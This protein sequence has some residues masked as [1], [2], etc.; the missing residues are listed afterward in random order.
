M[1][2]VWTS[3]AR[4]DFRKVNLDQVAKDRLGGGLVAPQALR[5]GIGLDQRNMLFGPAGGLEIGQGFLIDRKKADG[6]AVFGRHVGDRRPHRHAEVSERRPAIFDEL[7]DDAL[8]S[9]PFGDGQDEVGRRR[10]FAQR[11]HEA[12]ADHFGHVQGHR[13]TEHC[14]AGFDPAASPTQNAECVDHRRVA[15]R[16]EHRIGTEEELVADGLLVNDRR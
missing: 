16:A 4:F 10:A 9:Q 8:L 12:H 1:R 14:R 13:L 7:L 2:P 3:N 15:I 11:T 6:G 5:L